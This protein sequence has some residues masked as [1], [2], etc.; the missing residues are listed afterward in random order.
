MAY[1]PTQWRSGDTITSERLNKMENGIANKGNDFFN[2]PIVTL[3]YTNETNCTSPIELKT[4]AEIKKF[5]GVPVIVQIFYNG[6]G[7][8]KAEKFGLGRVQL[9]MTDPTSSTGFFVITNIID[10][11]VNTIDISDLEQGLQNY[12]I[13]LT[14][15]GWYYSFETNKWEV[16]RT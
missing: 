14:S 13:T 1:E 12:N 4:L 3:D 15:Y 9:K 11:P 6:Y 10:V 16:K 2:L 5:E 8:V 7:G